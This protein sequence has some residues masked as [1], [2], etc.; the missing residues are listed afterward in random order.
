MPPKYFCGECWICDKKSTKNKYLAKFFRFLSGIT[1]TLIK[2][3]I[4][5]IKIIEYNK[6]MYIVMRG[7][8]KE[9]IC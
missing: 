3:C 9:E 2:S 6:R 7:K 5:F 4:F 8:H 1:F